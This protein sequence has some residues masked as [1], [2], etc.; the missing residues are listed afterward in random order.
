MYNGNLFGHPLSFQCDK[1]VTRHKPLSQRQWLSRLATVSAADS[2]IDLYSSGPAIEKLESRMAELLG[3]DSALFVIKGMIGQ[4]S[5]LKQWAKV[6]GSSTIAV[7]PNS[8]I[9][10]DESDAYSALL[11]LDI[12]PFGQQGSAVTEQDIGTLPTE[13]A[14][15]CL[16][17]PVRREGFALP[18]LKVL[19]QT[20][21]FSQQH[22]IP[23]HIDG[24]RLFESAHHYNLSYADVAGYGDSVYV[25]LY[26]S[27]GAMAGGV[28]AGD[29]DFVDSL[30]SWRSRFGGDLFT[31][32]PY[33]LSA[34][35]GLEHYLPRLVEFHQR[36]KHLAACFVDSFGIQSVPK[37]V[38]S[39]GFLIDLP[40]APILFEQKVLQLAKED[41]I[42]LCDRIFA[43]ENNQTSRIEIQVGDALDDWQDSELVSQVVRLI[44][45]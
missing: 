43:V 19:K 22:K 37:A 38:N 31:A 13:L 3:K 8:H 41:K 35:W 23:V 15:L 14:A 33:V 4:N 36:A 9:V 21:A 1:F 29:S 2:T 45:S 32:F 11:G 7:H 12:V 24:A 39:N 42:W 44:D 18:E 30:Q 40:I 10:R 17:L 25:S 26:K 16:E 34:L 5:A 28:I 27:L 20:R 6:T